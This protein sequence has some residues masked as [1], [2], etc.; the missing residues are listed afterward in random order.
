MTLKARLQQGLSWLLLIWI[1]LLL[2][3]CIMTGLRIIFGWQIGVWR[4][5]TEDNFELYLGMAFLIYGLGNFS[6]GTL[7]WMATRK[8][9]FVSQFCGWLEHRAAA[10]QGRIRPHRANLTL[11]VIVFGLTLIPVELY[12][13]TFPQTLPQNLG[14]YLATRYTDQP[15][16]IY[17]YDPMLKMFRMRPNYDCQMYFNRFRWHHHTDALGFRNPLTRAQADV[18]VL[19]DSMIYGHGVEEH[20]TVRAFLEDL[21]QR[22]VVNFGMQGISIHQ[23]YQILTH[24]ATPLHPNDVLVFFTQ[25]DIDDLH[26]HLEPHDMQ[27]FLALPLEDHVTPYFE[28]APLPRSW[29]HGLERYVKELYVIKAYMFSKKYLRTGNLLPAQ[30]ASTSVLTDKDRAF[31]AFA[32]QFW[33]TLPFFEHSPEQRLGMQFH[34]QAL[35]KIQHFAEQSQFRFVCIFIYTAV[36]ERE[37]LYERVLQQYCHASGIPYLSLR[38]GFQEAIARGVQPYLPN[39]DMHFSPE[40]AH[41][42]AAILADTLFPRKPAT[43]LEP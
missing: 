9:W 17:R 3:S 21:L 23:A 19:G 36:G 10:F 2:F 15:G 18:I 32:G 34:L 27:Q 1:M 30:K 42:T 20:A 43:S 7:R 26:V 22:P 35:R 33:E 40:G 28:R 37:L 8:V 31:P 13:C 29:L 4:F 12:F 39:N 5:T 6:T 24:F 38:E 41:L 16:G 14:N 11:S 25:N